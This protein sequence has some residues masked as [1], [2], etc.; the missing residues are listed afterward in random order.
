MVGIEFLLIC[1][2]R[3]ENLEKFLKDLKGNRLEPFLKSEPIPDDNS[4]PVKVAVAKNF[5][6]LVTN[7]G[8]DTLIE[9]YAPW[10]GHCKKLAPV[11]DELGEALKNENVDIVKMDATSNDVPSPYDV[12]GFPTLYWSPRNKKSSPVRYE[13]RNQL[14]NLCHLKKKGTEKC[15]CQNF[16]KK[17]V[18]KGK[19]NSVYCQNA[20]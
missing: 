16:Q 11:Y 19:G 3:S 20:R 13:V 2:F 4:G 7:S 5:D 12:R 8:R 18:G 15:I 6:E 9:F 14:S 10:C 17:V 1:I